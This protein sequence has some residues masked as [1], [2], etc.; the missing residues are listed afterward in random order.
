MDVSAMGLPDG[1]DGTEHVL[2]KNAK[3]ASTHASRRHSSR[4]HWSTSGI[5]RLDIG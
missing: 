1:R 3:R 5:H 4:C 2:T